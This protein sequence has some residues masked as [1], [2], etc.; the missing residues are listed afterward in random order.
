[1]KISISLF[2]ILVI[3]NIGRAQHK[4]FLTPNQTVLLNNPAESNTKN[5]IDFHEFQ[6]NQP[7][8]ITTI[9]DWKFSSKEVIQ[10]N[11][12][13]FASLIPSRRRSRK[14]GISIG[15]YFINSLT[16]PKKEEKQANCQLLALKLSYK[17][18]FYQENTSDRTIYHLV[19]IGSAIEGY[20]NFAY[21]PST[22]TFQDSWG[23]QLNVGILWQLFV[24]KHKKDRV[25]EHFR[26]SVGL[27][28]RNI[29]Y[30]KIQAEL[31]NI[32][33]HSEHSSGSSWEK[34]VWLFYGDI[35][36]TIDQSEVFGGHSLSFNLAAKLHWNYGHRVRTPKAYKNFHGLFWG[37]Q[38][39]ISDFEQQLYAGLLIGWKSE[40]LK[41]SL[42][43]HKDLR[44]LDIHHVG[45]SLRYA[46]RKIHSTNHAMF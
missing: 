35:S 33:L 30:L 44:F 9:N 20:R 32:K 18:K 43:Y 14:K 42:N 7:A 29:P 45:F 27:S 36:T 8:N 11:Y 12:L 2:L 6:I 37:L 22:N 19:S 34:W 17:K 24:D 1:M 46:L 26:Y 41:I 3:T 28:V 39:G 13:E 10:H 21:P 23:S 40:R 16:F 4:T 25:P 5:L 15:S 31:F 38:T